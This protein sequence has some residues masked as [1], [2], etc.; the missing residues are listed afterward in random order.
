MELIAVSALNAN[1]ITKPYKNEQQQQKQQQQSIN[2]KWEPNY[3][4]AN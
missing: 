4:P 1:K 3:A 2:N